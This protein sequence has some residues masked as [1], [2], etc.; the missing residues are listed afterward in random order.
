[1]RIPLSGYNDAVLTTTVVEIISGEDFDGEGVVFWL[2]SLMIYNSHASIDAIVDLY[3]QDEGAVVAANQRG[4]IIA[5]YGTTTVV[6]FPAP[7]I[8]FRT[9]IGAVLGAG[10]VAAYECL[11]WGYKE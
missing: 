6:D 8:A 1:M 2:R 11:A 7:G 9:N 10:T 5:P 4:T 3:D